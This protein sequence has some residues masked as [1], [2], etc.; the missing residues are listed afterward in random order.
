MI[1]PVNKKPVLPLS[2][3]IEN[4]AGGNVKYT[5]AGRPMGWQNGECALIQPC[6]RQGD[7]VMAQWNGAIGW[8]NA[9]YLYY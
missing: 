7:W 8:T 1:S 6:S 2:K 4:I 3:V 5:N 9:N